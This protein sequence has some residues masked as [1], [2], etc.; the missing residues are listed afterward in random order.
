MAHRDVVDVHPGHQLV[1]IDDEFLKRVSILIHEVDVDVFITGVDLATTLIDRHENR[2][3]AR[4]GLCQQAGCSRGSDGEAG[5]V[6]A[7]IFHHLIIEFRI[8]LAEAIDVRI[9]L[10][11]MGII[12]LKRATLLGHLHRRAISSQCQG[13]VNA[14]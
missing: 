2:F 10:L 1:V 14:Y 6:A 11:T 3:D 9:V 5:N 12:N 8:G 4:G 7:S 13:F